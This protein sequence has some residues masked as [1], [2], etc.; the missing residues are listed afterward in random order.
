[1][2]YQ[3]VIGLEIHCELKTQSKMFCGCRNIQAAEPNTNVCPICLGMPGVLPVAN[4][5]AIEW[6]ILTGLAM[7]CKISS[8]SKFDRK[9]YF[10]PDLPKGYQISQYDLPL[11]KEG[12]LDVEVDSQV[13]R[14]GIERIHLEEDTGRLIHPKGA[15]YSLV[16]FSRSGV[17][18]IEIVTKPDL[19]SPKEARIFTQQLQQILRYLEVSDADMEKGQLRC[20]A[21]ISLNKK[22]AKNQKT[23]K[24]EIKNMNS[25]KAI[26][27]ALAY[28]IKRQTAIL[29]VGGRII[30][31]TRGFNEGKGRTVSQRTKEEAHDYRYFPEPDIPPL[32]IK[33]SQID[34]IRALLPEL[35][36]DK[37]QRFSKEY[38]LSPYDVEILTSN[39][40]LADFYESVCSEL[41]AWRRIV[42]PRRGIVFKR[43]AKMAANWVQ[44]EFLRLLNETK[45]P[46]S[47]IKL[48]A[49]NLAE[50]LIMIKKG[51]V[52]QLAAKKIFVKMFKT[53]KDPSEILQ[54]QG[55]H[56][57]TD[58][59]I[60]ENIIL[61]V[62]SNNPKAVSDYHKG[63]KQA[64]KFLMGQV[65]AQT[66]GAADPKLVKELLLQKLQTKN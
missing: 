54:D 31:E 28:E 29:E 59:Q 65:M 21:N 7:N 45:T 34:K 38:S 22:G 50:L 12:F 56:L 15:N 61:E 26:E 58:T 49:E 11:C 2:K 51:T 37:K 23:A 39:K 8:F 53:G 16:D 46:I 9:N 55:L 30:Q 1:M 41:L 63:K 57:V 10:Y 64:L 48:T 25:F 42:G 35:P 5:Q 27:K 13:K 24:V 20:D 17:P 32:T 47:K 18:L 4:K 36:Q 19:S 66:K 40:D 43:L 6:T 60:L 14:V 52:N 3:P 62:A 44:G 33:K